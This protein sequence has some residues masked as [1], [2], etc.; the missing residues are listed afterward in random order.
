MVLGA[1]RS[2]APPCSNLRSFGDK[3]SV[4]KETRGI[5]VGLFGSPNDSAPEALCPLAPVVTPLVW[6]FT[7]ECPAVKFPEPWMLNHF[8]ELTD[9]SYVGSATCPECP[10]KDWRGKLCWLNTRESSPEVVQSLIGVTTC[11]TLL[12]P[13]LLWSQ[14]KYVKL[15][16]TVRYSKSS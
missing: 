11:P 7:T 15:I 9:H 4:L 10:T 5:L 6:H 1:K 8:S 16:L 14:H 2:L 12:G 3:C 13:V